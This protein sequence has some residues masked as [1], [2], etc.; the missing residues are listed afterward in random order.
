MQ[1]DLDLK[2]EKKKSKS[3]CLTKQTSSVFNILKHIDYVLLN[4][5]FTLFSLENTVSRKL[6]S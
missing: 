2:L 4:F 3:M 6:A 5:S 1:S